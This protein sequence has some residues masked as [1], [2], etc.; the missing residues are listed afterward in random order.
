MKRLGK[1]FSGPRLFSTP[2]VRRNTTT[3]T[4]VVPQLISPTTS[5]VLM[6]RTASLICV[7][8]LLLSVASLRLT[9]V[10]ASTDEA[11]RT[12]ATKRPITHQDYDSW[13]SIQSPQISRD[14]KFVA[15]A[16]LPQDGDGDI[17][18]RNIATGV[19]WKAPRR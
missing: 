7:V 1:V 12:S 17:I 13:R 14:G 15:Y 9:H 2:V 11:Q 10:A 5:P 3:C 8:S 6:R 16:F 4:R 19:A 18:V